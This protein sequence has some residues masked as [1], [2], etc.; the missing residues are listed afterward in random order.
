MAD[1]S[2]LEWLLGLDYGP[3]TERV[4]KQALARFQ[5]DRSA[6][7]VSLPASQR[8]IDSDEWR[9]RLRLENFASANRLDYARRAD[10]QLYAEVDFPSEGDAD[11]WVLDIISTPDRR[12]A[13]G[14]TKSF[15]RFSH[16]Y[17]ILVKFVAIDLGH[18]VPPLKLIPRARE[19]RDAAGMLERHFTF[20][21][22]QWSPV[23]GVPDW[24]TRQNP[25]PEPKAGW[26]KRVREAGKQS[27][28]L[29]EQNAAGAA[30]QA[31]AWFGDGVGE[32]IVQHAAGF[33]LEFV[34]NKVVIHRKVSGP[35]ELTKPESLRE[36]FGIAV[37]LGPALAEATAA[38]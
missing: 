30:Q 13:V 15:G 33:H 36:L 37:A 27:K 5:A 12:V 10:D 22:A 31:S 17:G 19:N 29:A 38:Q 28:S 24:M 35:R 26:L 21:G 2:G 9:D 14:S 25:S 4:D 7:E 1:E 32:Q 3:L 8:T 23:D 20:D 18:E 11:V 6:L 34:E 16:G